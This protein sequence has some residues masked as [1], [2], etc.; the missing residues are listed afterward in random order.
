MTTLDRMT[1]VAMVELQIEA[2]RNLS[3][4]VIPTHEVCAESLAKTGMRPLQRDMLNWF[5][6]K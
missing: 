4:S 2:I 5:L 3:G 6:Q 1:V